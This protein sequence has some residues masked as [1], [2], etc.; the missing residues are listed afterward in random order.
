M[1]GSDQGQGR[2][3]VDERKFALWVRT[4]FVLIVITSISDVFFDIKQ[5]SSTLHIL[6]ECLLGVLAMA[7]LVVLFINT[8]TQ[9]RRNA[10][11]KSKLAEVIDQ[12][13]RESLKLAV[14]RR[15]F[16]EEVWRQFSDWTLTD[17]EAEV[18]FFTLKGLSAKEIANLRNASEKTVRNQLTSVYKK[19]GTT[20]KSGFIAW[21]MEGLISPERPRA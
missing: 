18:A 16:G 14:A 10:E 17:S 4:F 21:F 1:I 11:L 2:V 15:T 5:G 9:A 3:M 20:G 12:S 8:R 19:S 13:T 6:Q 7:L